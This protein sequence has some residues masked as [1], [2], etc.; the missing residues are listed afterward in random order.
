MRSVRPRSRAVFSCYFI[1][2]DIY[3]YLPKSNQSFL[4][5]R[6]CIH[7]FMNPVWKSRKQTHRSCMYNLLLGGSKKLQLCSKIN[8]YEFWSSEKWTNVQ[9]RS[10]VYKLGSFYK[11]VCVVKLFVFVRFSSGNVR[12]RVFYENNWNRAKNVK[13]TPMWMGHENYSYSVFS[14]KTMLDCWYVGR[15]RQ[16]YELSK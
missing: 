15:W 3:R 9:F 13:I 6:K 4:L 1:N 14:K 8:W 5:L 10:I 12:L 2:P 16:I 11:N 7:S